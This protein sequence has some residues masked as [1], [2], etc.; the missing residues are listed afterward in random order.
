MLKVFP[1][2]LRSLCAVLTLCALFTGS[3]AVTCAGN[4]Q[5]PQSGRRPYIDRGA[6]EGEACSYGFWKPLHVTTLY[7]RPDERSRKVGEVRPGPCVEALTGEV[8]VIPGSLLVTKAHESY[9]P[10]DVLGVYTYHGEDTYKIRYRGR[11][12]TENLS[13][14]TAVNATA[15]SCE[16]EPYCW[17]VFKKKPKSV[18]WVK[19]RNTDGRIGWTY[20]AGNFEHPYWLSP[21][22]CPSPSKRTRDTRRR[23]S[24]FAGLPALP[25]HQ[26]RTA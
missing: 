10:G 1:P 7:A 22:D 24:R 3:P 21:G 8:H 12:G 5:S 23:P 14:S 4:S 17:G 16:L 6:C 25:T 18:W 26:T 20:H 15:K 11:W 2:A 19:I 9:K 13:Y